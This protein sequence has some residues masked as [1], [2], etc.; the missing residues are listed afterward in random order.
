MSESVITNVSNDVVAFVKKN[1]L[2]PNGSLE[3]YQDKLKGGKVIFG[4][5]INFLISVGRK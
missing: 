3:Y 5:H 1:I 4:Q 2:R